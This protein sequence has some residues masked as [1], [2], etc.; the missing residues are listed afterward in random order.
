MAI[1]QLS[2]GR[3]SFAA[4]GL[5]ACMELMRFAPGA[6]SGT[7]LN[8]ERKGDAFITEAS[9]VSV[10]MKPVGAVSRLGRQRFRV[11]VRNS[12]PAR[13]EWSLE[14]ESSRD[15]FHIL[16]GFL[17]GDNNLSI[18][19]PGHFPNLTRQTGNRSCS[20]A[21]RMRTD[22]CAAPVAMAFIDGLGGI[23]IAGPP[24]MDLPED[25][26]FVK[27]GLIAELPATVGFS[28]GY[29]NAP[30]TFVNKDKFANSAE[31]CLS[32]GTCLEFFLDFL[33]LPGVGRSSAFKIVREIYELYH[34]P[35]RAAISNAACTE[36]IG[37]TLAVDS[38]DP[39]HRVFTG[40]TVKGL[41]DM[42][43]YRRVGG[44]AIAWVG[45]VN[46]A[47]PLLLASQRHRRPE[48]TNIAVAGLDRIAAHRNPANG[49][50]FDAFTEDWKP[51]V[52][53]WWSGNTNHDLHSAYTNAEA[54]Y[55]LL[56]ACLLQREAGVSIS[57]SWSASALGALTTI[58]GLQRADG[59]C[60]YA[61]FQDRTEVASWDGFAGCWWVPTFCLA[62]RLTGDANWLVAAERGAHFYGEQVKTLNVWGTPMDTWK[63]ND[64][65]G[66]LAF[67]RGTRLLHEITG[68]NEWLEQLA[69]AAE[70]EFLWRYM[71]NT[72]P[73]AE[74]L[75]S[76]D[77]HS[78]GG[79]ITSVSN[80]H[81]HPMG[82]LIAGDLAY[83]YAHNG[84]GHVRA[85]LDDSLIW[86]RNSIELF[87][88]KTGY[89]RLGW[90]GE[91]YCP[92][93]GLLIAKYRDGSLAST[94][95]GLNQWAASAMLEGLI[96]GAR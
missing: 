3:L 24:H 5:K 26:G 7:A 10:V 86:A 40:I 87:P 83:L 23:A 8:F 25:K 20:S 41:P 21:W 6:T 60:G 38:W 92:S 51:T 78:C 70:Y 93:D 46:S 19:A 94:E 44:R 73:D 53:S 27:T 59:H 67:I 63:A 52:N 69:G 91:R 66:V 9:G 35:P 17:F 49:L 72:H 34:D 74:P 36:A 77:W 13:L 55:Y 89:G 75:K 33:V 32:A 39:E 22:R 31:A 56:K 58:R 15:A 48:W 14:A 4:D 29:R 11:E 85:R 16:P 65:E 80:P 2:D 79:S 64:Q 43:E 62:H 95:L 30:L 1:E 57:E 81:I 61:Y 42:P 84:D 28:L 18:S 90:S 82:L 71:Y 45:G 88:E 12:E 54:A 96:E 68:R 76:A 37:A 50:F 47:Y